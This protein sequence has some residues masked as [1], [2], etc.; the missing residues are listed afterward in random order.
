MVPKKLTSGVH[1]WTLDINL[2]GTSCS[3]GVGFGVVSEEYTNN[4]ESFPYSSACCRSTDGSSNQMQNIKTVNHKG[5]KNECILD[6][7]NDTFTIK[8]EG[9]VVSEKKGGLKGKAWYPFL[10]FDEKGIVKVSFPGGL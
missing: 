5:K 10:D 3:W 8:C 4:F 6:F 9:E 7:N 1:R 2:T